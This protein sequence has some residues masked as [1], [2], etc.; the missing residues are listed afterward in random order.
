[1]RAAFV[2]ALLILV[3]AVWLRRLNVG[4]PLASITFVVG[5]FVGQRH[6]GAEKRDGLF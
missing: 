6:V 1:M 5:W 2:A 3:V 4:V